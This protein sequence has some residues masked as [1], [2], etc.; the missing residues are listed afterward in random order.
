MY[1][2]ADR[3]EQILRIFEPPV[4]VIDNAAFRVAFNPIS[5]DEPSKR[6]SPVHLIPMRLGWNTAHSDM[7]VD[8]ENCLFVVSVAFVQRLD[9]IARQLQCVNFRPSVLDPLFLPLYL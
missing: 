6:S 2:S 4:G 8:D 1:D 3:G 5:V 7:V 9:K